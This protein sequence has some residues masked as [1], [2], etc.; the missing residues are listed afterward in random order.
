MSS[1][2]ITPAEYRQIIKILKS[3]QARFSEWA[4]NDFS[5]KEM[6]T[7][8][9]QFPVVLLECRRGVGYQL[10]AKKKYFSKTMIELLPETKATCAKIVLKQKLKL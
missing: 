1:D 8:I 10:R 4:G 5:L 6:I 9:K 7:I 2:S 3:E